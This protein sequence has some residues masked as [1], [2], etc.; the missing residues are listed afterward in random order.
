MS[1]AVIGSKWRNFERERERE[2]E[3]ER[4]RK[5]E[6]ERERERE[7]GG[8]AVL[9]QMRINILVNNRFLGGKTGNRF[10][11]LPSVPETLYPFKSC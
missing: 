8:G 5:R 3:G 9:E 1:G 11:T 2:R 4:E 7:R 6:R 10:A